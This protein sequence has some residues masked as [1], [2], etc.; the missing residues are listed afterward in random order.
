MNI[1]KDVL[2]LP[3]SERAESRNT[4]AIG[5]D[6]AVA[7]DIIAVRTAAAE[8]DDVQLVR[9]EVFTLRSVLHDR[10]PSSGRGGVLGEKH[11][12]VLDQPVDVLARVD[13][14]A[15]IGLVRLN[16]RRK[17]GI[18]QVAHADHAVSDTGRF[19]EL[20]KDNAVLASAPRIGGALPGSRGLDVSHSRSGQFV[21]LLAGNGIFDGCNGFQPCIVVDALLSS[22]AHALTAFLEAMAATIPLD[23]TVVRL[24]AAFTAGSPA[25]LP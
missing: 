14:L 7:T 3:R 6:I 20:A 22:E 1:G 19:A 5:I 21:Q 16:P 2:M 17:S 25:R 9:L 23:S 8:N 13:D 18:F 15:S 10:K 4:F 12:V 24:P 11:L